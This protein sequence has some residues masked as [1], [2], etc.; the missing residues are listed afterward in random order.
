MHSTKTTVL[1][2]RQTPT[3]PL[4]TR[5]TRAGYSAEN[6][7]V[8][9]E[10]NEMQIVCVWCIHTCDKKFVR[11]QKGA[12]VSERNWGVFVHVRLLSH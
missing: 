11:C 5:T 8:E 12:R 2:T 1:R 3:R 9:N 10:D 6:Q 7:R 4:P